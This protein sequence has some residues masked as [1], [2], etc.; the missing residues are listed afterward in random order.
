MKEVIIPAPYDA[1]AEQKKAY[2]LWMSFEKEVLFKTRY[3]VVHPLLDELHEYLL[4]NELRIVAGEVFYRARIIND[5]AQKDYMM[6][7]CVGEDGDY[8]RFLSNINKFKGLTKEASYVPPDNR[9]IKDGRANPRYI[10]YLYMAESP[11]TAI[12][13]VRPLI[14][15][16]INVSEIIVKNDLLIA[17]LTFDYYSVIPEKRDE[18]QW[19]LYYIHRAFSIPTIDPDEY[20]P[21]QIIAE[22]IKQWGYDG[23]RY[24]SSLHRGGVNITVY[25]YEKCDAISSRDM[26]IDT[27]KLN[28]RTAGDLTIDDNMLFI[29]D[30][31]SYLINVN[32]ITNIINIPK[33]KKFKTNE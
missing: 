19:L 10:K 3:Y 27:I 11:T 23:I 17:N 13:E 22:N 14:T 28:A 1:T 5:S 30:N 31:E 26:I 4:K 32:D 25:N 15:D 21:S 20:L 16:R 2:E 24:N 9:V 12:Y 6:R 7:V 18:I 33:H 29:K 8:K